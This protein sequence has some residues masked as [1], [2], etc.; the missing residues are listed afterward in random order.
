MQDWTQYCSVK[1]LCRVN[2]RIELSLAVQEKGRLAPRKS[3]REWGLRYLN[4]TVLRLDPG[5]HG[6]HGEI[7]T[8]DEGRPA[9]AACAIYKLA[10]NEVFRGPIDGA[11]CSFYRPALWKSDMNG[12]AI[13]G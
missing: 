9:Y 6:F 2:P 8:C 12:A 4:R 10:G 3:L 13:A 7:L 1:S 11:S 5:F